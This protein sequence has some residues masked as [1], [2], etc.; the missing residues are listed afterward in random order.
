MCVVIYFFYGDFLWSGVYEIV[1]V[2]IVVVEGG[3]C[4][5]EGFLGIFICVVVRWVFGGGVEEGWCG[6]REDGLGKV[7]GFGLERLWSGF[8][9]GGEYWF[10]LE[11]LYEY[12]LYN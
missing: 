7:V 8:D 6:V 4:W 2:E 11:L 5:L 1:N 12:G 3:F 10:C 9:M